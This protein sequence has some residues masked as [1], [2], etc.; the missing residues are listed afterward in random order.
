MDLQEAIKSRRTVHA[1]NTNKVPQE[2]VERA[3]E[4]TN[5]APCHRLTFPWRFVSIEREDREQLVRLELKIKFADQTLD[6][7][8]KQKVSKKILDPSHLIVVSQISNHDPKRKLEDYA[9]CACA[10][11]NLLL[12]LAGDGVGSK[13]S[14]GAITTSACTYDIV[15]I[16]PLEE[17]IIGF[18]WVGYGEIPPSINRPLVNSIFRK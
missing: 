1:F 2:F 15:G 6:Q 12:S 4:A 7:A 18:I 17:E 10:I 5:H 11:Q 13:W 16:D 9:A 8:I 14:T 3:I